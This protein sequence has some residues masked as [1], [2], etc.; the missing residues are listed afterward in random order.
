MMETKSIKIAASTY[1]LLKQTA[2]R[3]H[4]TLQAVLDKLVKEYENRKFFEA[5]NAAY[6][7]MTS[8]EWDHE[9]KERSELD[10]ITGVDRGEQADE[11]W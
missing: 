4:R 6:Q 7:N 11:T 2:K 9:L 8:E 5:V 3:E 10:G 1:D